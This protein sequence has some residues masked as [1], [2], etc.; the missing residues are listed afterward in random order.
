MLLNFHALFGCES[1]FLELEQQDMM[2]LTKIALA[3]T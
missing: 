1:Y 3:Y 2:G